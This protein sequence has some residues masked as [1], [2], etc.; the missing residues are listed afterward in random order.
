MLPVLIPIAA[1]AGLDARLVAIVVALAASYAFML[2]VS[3]PPNAIVFGSGRIRMAD[4]VRIG[5]VCNL[6]AAGLA[7]LWA[8]FV[9]PAWSEWALADMVLDTSQTICCP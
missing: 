3:T 9:L 6:I 4:M 8:F 1:A 5:L 7:I 2:P